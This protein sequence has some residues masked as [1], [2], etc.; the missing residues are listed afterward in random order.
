MT[1]TVYSTTTP[2]IAQAKH[3]FKYQHKRDAYVD[4]CYAILTLNQAAKYAEDNYK[5]YIYRL[6]HQ[7]I[8]KLYRQGFCVQVYEE[9]NIIHFRFKVDG[10]I[11]QWH[12]PVSVVTWPIKENHAAVFYEWHDDLPMRTRPLHEAI[13]LLEWCLA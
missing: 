7:W 1:T 11:F 8:E 4:C 5:F 10:I 9:C 3:H 12:L 6:K 13:A 2:I